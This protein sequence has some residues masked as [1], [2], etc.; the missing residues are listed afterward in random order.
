MK[1]INEIT[2]EFTRMISLNDESVSDSVFAG[3]NK[4]R[5]SVIFGKDEDTDDP[6][7]IAA[8]E[9]IY[10]KECCSKSE[11]VQFSICSTE[12]NNDQFDKQS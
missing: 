10:E 8:I 4:I 12:I 2:F 5:G 6:D 11:D 3:L 1:T 9:W 7:I